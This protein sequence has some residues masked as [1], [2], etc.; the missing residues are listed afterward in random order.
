M[1]RTASTLIAFSDSS[2]SDLADENF[3][4]EGE[5]PHFSFE[6][7]YPDGGLRAWLVVLGV[8]CGVCATFGFINAWGVFQA[9]Y[10]EFYLRGTDPSTIA[11]IGSV[12]YALVF[13]PGLAFG[14]LFD[15]G[16][17][18]VPVLM[19]SVVLVVSTILT[20]QCTKFWHLLLCQGFAVGLSSGTIFTA[21]FGTVPHWFKKRLGIAFA[22][23]AIG[24]S[25]GGTVFPIILKNLIAHQRS[26]LYFQWTM[27]FTALILLGFLIVCN[28]TI[29]RRLPPRPTSGPFIDLREFKSPA[30]S[31]YTLSAF[32]AFLGLYTC[33]TYIDISAVL[34]GIDPDFAFYLLSIANASSVIG[35]LG[36]GIIADRKGPLNAM[37]P[38]TL[39]A[40]VMT[41]IWPFVT[42]KGAF[43]AVAVIY[44]ISSGIFISLMGQPI[45]RMGD[46]NIKD[47][48]MRCGM[49][50]TVL[51]F[52][53]LAGP[54][55]SGAIQNATGDFKGVGIY[56][57]TCI[58]MSVLLLVI[59]RQ[60]MLR[61]VVG[62]A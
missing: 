41:Y 14:R 32:T 13:M 20:G 11:W 33:L 21:A 18:R 34:A 19:A 30:F 26:L 15:M 10:T 4:S 46:G 49:A 48:G 5:P 17:L 51:S 25:I 2:R 39:I 56:A 45:V 54:P 35:R 61:K 60:I 43:V 44:G 57:G 38:G 40:G 47:I 42:S 6:D 28:L 23:M 53:A 27:R 3:K 31:L 37:I 12:Q 58:M 9:Y 16:H 8:T 22:F 52:G 7:E 24:S 29:A 50:S 36:S 59:T 62:N 55:I 1:N